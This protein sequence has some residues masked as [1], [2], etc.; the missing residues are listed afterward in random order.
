MTAKLL[1]IVLLVLAIWAGAEIM[2]KGTDG[3][4]GGL[5]ARLSGKPAAAEHALPIPKRIGEKVQHEL[6]DAMERR[7]SD[8]EDND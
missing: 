2:T 6:N 8:E 3:A 7:M 1:G 5:F 4:F